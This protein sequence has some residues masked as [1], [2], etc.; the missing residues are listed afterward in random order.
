MREIVDGF[1]E[2][3]SRFSDEWLVTSRAALLFLLSTAIVLAV[4]PVFLG[5]IDR[6]EMSF[7]T[8]LPWGI[9][10]ML[11]AVAIFFLWLGMWQ[12]WRRID[13]SSPRS[14]RLWFWVLLLGLWW[15]G[16]LYCLSVYLPQVIRR[17]KAKT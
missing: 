5:R 9:L 15:G 12:Y 4:T 7:W 10:G 16:C 17:N 3:A 6:D 14:K 1:L 2:L 11:G 13:R 8:R